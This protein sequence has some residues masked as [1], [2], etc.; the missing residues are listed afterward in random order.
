M[1]D[2]DLGLEF[3]NELRPVSF[4]WDDRGGH[5][6]SREHMGF[7]AQEVAST[8]GDQASDRAVWIDAPAE[9]NKNADGEVEESPD[10]Q[11][12]R[13]E[14]LI[15]PLVKAVQELTARLEALEAE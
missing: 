11:G 13:Y 4:V 3:V 15:A 1:T 2:L 6:G 12:L 7:I 14:E 8:L 10:R 5:V 9:T